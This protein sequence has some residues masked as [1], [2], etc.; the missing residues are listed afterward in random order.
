MVRRHPGKA[1]TDSLFLITALVVNNIFYLK[2]LFLTSHHALILS[3]DSE[4]VCAKF[5]ARFLFFVASPKYLANVCIFNSQHLNDSRTGMSE[6]DERWWCTCHNHKYFYLYFAAFHFNGSFYFV[7]F[8]GLCLNETS[9]DDLSNAITS[10]GERLR[11]IFR[12]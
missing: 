2:I 1:K 7:Y 8:N 12:E 11:R 5:P 4:K 6:E 9:R 10:L 3:V